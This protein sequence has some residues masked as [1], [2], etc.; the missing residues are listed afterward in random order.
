MF[1]AA[2]PHRCGRDGVE[3]PAKAFMQSRGASPL[4]DFLNGEEGLL[5]D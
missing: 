1:F 2:L 3:V 4:R 5:G